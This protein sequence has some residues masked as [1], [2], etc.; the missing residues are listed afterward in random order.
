[1]QKRK[2]VMTLGLGLL[3]NWAITWSF[4]FLLYP[5]VIANFG[6]ILGGFVMTILSFI[7]CYLTILFYDGTKK[8]WLGIE[9]L[10]SIEDFKTKALPQFFL[11]RFATQIYNVIGTVLAFLMRKSDLLLVVVLSIKFDPFITVVHI[12]HGAHQYNGLSARDWRVFLTSLAIGN[13]YWTL[14]VYL[15]ITLFDLALNHIHSLINFWF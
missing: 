3:G 1:M 10:K 9:T 11:F 12:R 14:A 4:D 5:Y 7:I 6:I 15:G 8:D 13:I 2:W